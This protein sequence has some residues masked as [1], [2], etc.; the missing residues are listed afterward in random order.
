MK[1]DYRL[2]I[3]DILQ[4]IRKIEEYSKGLSSDE[5]FKEEKNIDAVV[6]NFEIIGE[7]VKN[8]PKKIREKY[9]DVPWKIMAGMRDKLI[10]EYFGVNIEILWK[11][12][13]E[14]LP[15]VKPLIKKVLK[16]INR[17][18]ENNLQHQKKLIETNRN[19]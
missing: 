3:D 14:D 5:F 15:K 6:R 9:P 8:I 2:Y 13:K 10:H 17:E 16:E 19:L 18:I 11:T 1:R 12:L 7:A 4:A